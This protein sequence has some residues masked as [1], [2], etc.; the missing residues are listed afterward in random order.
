MDAGTLA[1][2]G[3]HNRVNALAAAAI[4]HQAGVE[5]DIG[6]LRV[7]RGLPHR[8]YLV[9]EVDGV[10]Y[11]DDSKATNVGACLAALDG[12][13]TGA[14]NLVLISG[15]AANGASFEA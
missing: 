10:R 8:S 3:R 15:G 11:V 6:A 2:Q 12:F 13:G 1:L 14:K 7:F 9:A 4:V 5:P